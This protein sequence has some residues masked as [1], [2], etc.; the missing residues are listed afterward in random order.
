M[1]TLSLLSISIFIVLLVACKK[2]KDCP[3]FSQSDLQ[4]IA[5]NE[6]DTLKFVNQ[7]DEEYYIYIQDFNLSEAFEQECVEIENVC[8]C[9]NSVEVMAKNST[10]NT[11]YVFLKMEQSDVSEMQYFYYKVNDFSFE[12]DFDNELQ[13]ADQFPYLEAEDYV[14]INNVQYQDV[15]IYSNLENSSSNV[16]KVFL[17]K[18]NGILR[19][20]LKD[21]TI[22]DRVE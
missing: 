21:N 7:Q 14:T 9:L 22:W 11:S 17:N 10:T 8:A 4:Y 3:G 2:H 20:H 15:A 12:I 1:K 13:Y 6:Y 5:Y 18:A 19:I 16:L